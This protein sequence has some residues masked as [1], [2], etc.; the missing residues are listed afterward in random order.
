MVETNLS[1]SLPLLNARSHP[2]LSH[3]V[4]ISFSVFS[5]LNP[6]LT[7]FFRRFAIPS[8]ARAL[9]LA[10]IGSACSTTASGESL[11]G[12]D[13]GNDVERPAAGAATR[14]HYQQQP[15]LAA[16]DAVR[17]LAAVEVDGGKGQSSATGGSL[18]AMEK[19]RT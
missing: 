17:Q 9:L 19:S 15:H 12:E 3:P 13:R 10:A 14:N 4:L 2:N 1:S 16:V 5:R 8:S 18:F 6:L 11:R 7:L